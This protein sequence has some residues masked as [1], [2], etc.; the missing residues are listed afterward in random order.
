MAEDKKEVEA[1][2]P[3]TQEFKVK[4]EFTLDKLYKVGSKIDL[5]N[6]KLKDTLISNKFI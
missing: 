2:Q 1:K 6:G 3:K 5:P 4:Q